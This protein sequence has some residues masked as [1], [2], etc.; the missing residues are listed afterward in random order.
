MNF[1][2]AYIGFLMPNRFSLRA[3]FW[4]LWTDYNW[5]I[6]RTLATYSPLQKD[7]KLKREVSFCAACVDSKSLALKLPLF[8]VIQSYIIIRLFLDLVRTIASIILMIAL[9][10]VESLSAVIWRIH[11][12]FISF[13]IVSAGWDHTSLY[14]WLH[15]SF[16]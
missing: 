4:V 8:L 11:H 6:T 7:V 13:R 12:S 16:I 10:K 5:E 9:N 2:F 1:K 14:P 3:F 15:V